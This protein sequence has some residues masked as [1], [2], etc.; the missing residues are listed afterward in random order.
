MK[1][2]M[3]IT[4]VLVMAG[5]IAGPVFAQ[6]AALKIGYVDL[7]KAYFDYEKRKTME[8]ELEDVGNSKK[9]EQDKLI[10]EVKTMSGEAEL[11]SDAVKAEKN[12]QLDAKKAELAEFVKNARQ[13][14]MTKQNDMFKQV[15]DDIEKVTQE[16]GKQS[17]YD[18][19]V[20]SRNV[21]YAK[22][23]YDLTDQVL[24]GLNKGQAAP[25]QGQQAVSSDTK[26]K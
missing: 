26:K 17:G 25:A 7:R 16:I 24:K 19:I 14:Y 2:L 18:Y 1:K 5:L 8:K 15:I 22:P 9:A 3:V 12:K 4:A 10:G 21:M 11:A 6:S 23:E 20:D 13:E